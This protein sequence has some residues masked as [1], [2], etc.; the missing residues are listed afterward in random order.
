KVRSPQAWGAGKSKTTPAISCPPPPTPTPPLL[1]G[2]AANRVS[3]CAALALRPADRGRTSSRDHLS[4]SA[5]AA[6]SI[7]PAR[8]RHRRRKPLPRPIQ[9]IDVAVLTQTR[10]LPVPI[11]G[12]LHHQY[13]RV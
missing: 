6:P 8:A 2:I 7:S 1:A 11:L 5:C 4:P 9:A 10:P 13:I 12:G 3:S